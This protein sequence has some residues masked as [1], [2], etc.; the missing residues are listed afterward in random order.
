MGQPDEESMPPSDPPSPSTSE[1][2]ARVAE[3]TISKK[4]R[5]KALEQAAINRRKELES[6][7]QER[8][9]QRQRL[10]QLA[11][12]TRSK[13]AAQE[14][15]EPQGSVHNTSERVE[16]PIMALINQGQPGSIADLPQLPA[17]NT[18][19]KG[20]TSQLRLPGSQ[21]TSATNRAT[22]KKSGRKL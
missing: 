12:A 7:K 16:P 11:E 6:L 20:K 18:K 17:R 19:G 14:I 10:Q 13:R 3:E 1:E 21:V 22:L 8:E 9:R 5:E 4:R 2:E 15:S